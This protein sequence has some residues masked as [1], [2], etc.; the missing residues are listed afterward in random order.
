MNVGTGICYSAALSEKSLLSLKILKTIF[1]AENDIL[2]C[3]NEI[4]KRDQMIHKVLVL[5]LLQS[6]LESKKY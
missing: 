6:N 4:K 5:K 2:Y 1:Q 3:S